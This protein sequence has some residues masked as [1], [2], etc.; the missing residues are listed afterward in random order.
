M[1]N[2]III[3]VVSIKISKIRMLLHTYLLMLKR[4]NIV[5][6]F[7]HTVCF[8]FSILPLFLTGI[9]IQ[10]LLIERVFGRS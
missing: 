9:Y 3:E 8:R 4:Y 7:R 10:K 6:D 2:E 1:M 5:F